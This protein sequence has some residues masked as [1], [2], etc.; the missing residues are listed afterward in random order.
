MPRREDR[1]P[2]AL[3]ALVLAALAWSAW[4]PK[5]RVTW[6]LEVLPVLIVVPLLIATRRRFPFTSLLYLLGALHCLIL[7]VGGHYTY[8]EVPLGEW[9]RE[10][11][12]LARNHYDR[13]G[14]VAQGFVPALAIRELALRTSPLSRGG[15]LFV[16]SLCVPLAFSAFYEMLEWWA[17]LLSEEASESFLGTQGDDWDT[18]WDMFACL[19]GAL[20]ALLLLSPLHDRQLEAME[21][22]MGSGKERALSPPRA[23]LE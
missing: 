3:L 1:L 16:L 12:G 8:A 7:I 14:H 22:A 10:R 2:L 4:E 15:W 13:L 17:A 19:C 5:D 11:F 20:A 23:G 21:S 6:W 9:A 18:Q